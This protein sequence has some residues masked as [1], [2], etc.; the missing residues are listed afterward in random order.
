[1]G[2]VGV[3]SITLVYTAADISVFWFIH[4]L[5]LLFCCSSLKEDS[6]KEGHGLPRKQ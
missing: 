3:W 1:M 5:V 4:S 2:V 6:A